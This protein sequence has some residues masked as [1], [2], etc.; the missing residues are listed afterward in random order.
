MNVSGQMRANAPTPDVGI[1]GEAAEL[2]RVLGGIGELLD[3]LSGRLSPVL[4]P[5]DGKAGSAG[6]VPHQVVAR[7][8]HNERLHQ[9]VLRAEEFAARVRDWLD[10]LDC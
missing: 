10:R 6:A 8:P 9:S 7:A 5:D 3:N 2:E 4:R 1:H